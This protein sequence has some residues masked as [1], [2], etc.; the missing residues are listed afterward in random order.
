M[1][2]H[3]D[4]DYLH[5]QFLFMILIFKKKPHACMCEIS[6]IILCIVLA[7]HL[8]VSQLIPTKLTG[9]SHTYVFAATLGRQ[10]PP[11]LHWFGTHG[12]PKKNVHRLLRVIL[13]S[14]LLTSFTIS[15]SKTKWTI[16][17]VSIETVRTASASIKTW[18]WFTNFTYKR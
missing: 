8:L 3:F 17:R 12:S 15:T 13:L 18:I 6:S 11:F 5:K 9:H 1:F 14:H 7:N 4:M 16:A 10:R 2:H